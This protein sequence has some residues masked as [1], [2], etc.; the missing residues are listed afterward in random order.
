[1]PTSIYDEMYGVS[2]ISVCVCLNI[3]IC[4]MLWK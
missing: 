3:L 4:I 1:M 2:Q